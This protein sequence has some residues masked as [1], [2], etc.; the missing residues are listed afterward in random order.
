M[1]HPIIQLDADI[2]RWLGSAEAHC[3][4]IVENYA[5]P[6]AI[7]NDSFE[8]IYVINDFFYYCFTKST[9]TLAAINMLLD[10]GFGEDA[11]ILVRASYE[12]YLAIA[13]LAAHPERLDDLV[14]KKI[15]LK[16]GDFEHPVTPAG[17]K[18]YR[19]VVDLETGETLPFSLSVAEMSALTKYPEDLV[20]HQLLYGFLSEHCHA[21]MM[22]SGNYRDPSN[23]RYVVFNLSQTLQAK[24]YALY[25]YT[26]SISELARFQKLKAVHRDRTKRTL[27]RAIYLLDRSFKLLIFNDELKALPASMKARVKHCEFLAS[28]A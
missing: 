23:R 11:Q 12:N 8:S 10:D 17:R 28:D 9:K 26:L 22:A 3:Q 19:K 16:T 14:T 5:L 2:R 21:H 24:V 27:R 20:V 25:V 1:R 15:G 7:L 13:F 18:D 6:L 4:A